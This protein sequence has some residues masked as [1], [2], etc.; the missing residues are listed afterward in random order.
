LRKNYEKIHLCFSTLLADGH[1]AVAATGAVLAL[2][3]ALP[4]ARTQLADERAAGLTGPALAS[5]ALLRI[6]LGTAL[7]EEVVF[8]GVL[9]EGLARR[10]PRAPALLASSAAFGLWHV[11]PTLRL[12]ELNGVD[13]GRARTALAVSASVTATA[14]AGL[15]FAALRRWGGGLAAPVVAHA[16]V[17]VASLLAAVAYQRTSLSATRSTCRSS[18]RRHSAHGRPPRGA[19][20]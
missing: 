6:P 16:G 4:G 5:Y 11:G 2:A 15:G 17:N 12:L 1:D 14:A 10:L 9:T 19:R 20:R 7:P 18:R 3:R 8:R 13:L